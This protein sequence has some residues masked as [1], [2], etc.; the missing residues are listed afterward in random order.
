LAIGN[1]PSDIVKNK[2]ALENQY[3]WIKQLQK[4]KKDMELMPSVYPPQT[5]PVERLL[6][7]IYIRELLSSSTTSELK[8]AQVEHKEENLSMPNNLGDLEPNWQKSNFLPSLPQQNLNEQ[9]SRLESN[10][11]TERLELSKEGSPNSV[12]QSSPCSLFK[13]NARPINFP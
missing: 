5:N 8:A 9:N 7:D 12:I 13:L 10:S 11:D 4:K 2:S 6:D 1:S 3:N